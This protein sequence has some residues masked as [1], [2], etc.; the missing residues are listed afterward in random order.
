MLWIAFALFIKPE[1]LP[2]LAEATV[3]MHTGKKS[4][5]TGHD[6]W[7]VTHLNSHLTLRISHLTPHT[8]HLTPHTPH[9]TPHTSLLTP[10]TSHQ[11]LSPP[12]CIAACHHLPPT[13]SVRGE[14]SPQKVEMWQ[15]IPSACSQSRKSIENQKLNH[16]TTALLSALC[17][18]RCL[19]ISF[20]LI[21]S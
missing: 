4:S 6:L 12:F 9:P 3:M 11:R 8:S 15:L 17:K 19:S 5:R 10:H 1:Y 2:S 16:I 7:H 20:V 21:H 14:Q 18:I 13:S